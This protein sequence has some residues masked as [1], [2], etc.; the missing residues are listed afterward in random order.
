MFHY[1]RK[2]TRVFCFTLFRYQ[3]KSSV[4]YVYLVY[5]YFKCILN[6]SFLY[7]LVIFKF[8]HKKFCFDFSLLLHYDFL[9]LKDEKKNR[10]KNRTSNKIQ[11]DVFSV[12]RF[13]HS[14]YNKLLKV[15]LTY[16]LSLVSLY[17]I[18]VFLSL[19][20]LLFF[21]LTAGYSPFLFFFVFA[22][23]VYVLLFI[24]LFSFVYFN[25]ID[26]FSAVFFSYTIQRQFITLLSIFLLFMYSLYNYFLFFFLSTYKFDCFS[27]YFCF[28]F[29]F[30]SSPRF[31]LIHKKYLYFYPLSQPLRTKIKNVMKSKFYS[32]V[33]FRRVFCFYNSIL[34]SL[35]DSL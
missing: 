30:F 6:N 15:T 3:I 31:F 22:V 26:I 1:P 33:S 23:C 28:K 10:T 5:K 35:A 17:F 7:F 19:V 21:F 34:F 29:I 8:F 2:K 14:H 24:L 16:T 18:L 25:I 13:I 27:L 4:F 12:F 11:N 20:L 9:H 32:R